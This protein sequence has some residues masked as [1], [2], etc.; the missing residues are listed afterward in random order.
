MDVEMRRSP[1]P[2]TSISNATSRRSSLAILINDD[3]KPPTF[4]PIH[5]GGFTSSGLVHSPSPPMSASMSSKGSTP[6]KHGAA[7]LVDALNS[8]HDA[9]ASTSSVGSTSHPGAS[10]A[11][12]G[13]GGGAGAPASS[14]DA[15]PSTSAPSPVT[16]AAA[17]TNETKTANATKPLSTVKPRSSKPAK[18]ARSPSPSPPPP[19]PPAP[20]TT[21]RLAIQLGGPSNYEVDIR[22]RAKETGQ[23]PETPPPAVKINDSSDEDEEEPVSA[24][25]GAKK[26]KKVGIYHVDFVFS[27]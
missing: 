13:A 25:P 19:V 5:R 15:G 8:I 17:V 6:S 11:K 26:K 9:A 22:K 16:S 27:T 12:S 14:A 23:R 20:M 18:P 2:P 24:A 1:S 4:I 3:Y 7:G 10:G 21:I